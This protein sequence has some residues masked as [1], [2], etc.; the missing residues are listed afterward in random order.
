MGQGGERSPRIHK[1]QHTD[2]ATATAATGTK[3]VIASRTPPLLT[4]VRAL[5]AHTRN[6]DL[7]HRPVPWP[8][9]TYL[10]RRAV[11]SVACWRARPR[12]QA[13]WAYHSVRCCVV[14]PLAA[15]PLADCS[16]PAIPYLRL[17]EAASEERVCC[18]CCC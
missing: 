2:E 8:Q 17:L 3:A 7:I 11:L 1:Q 10:S 13:G 5:V 15:C 18:C 6:S 4:V 14:Y 12:L 16:A 9:S